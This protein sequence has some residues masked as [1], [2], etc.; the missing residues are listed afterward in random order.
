MQLDPRFHVRYDRSLR[1][2]RNESLNARKK[3]RHG[4]RDHIWWSLVSKYRCALMMMMMYPHVR[5]HAHLLNSVGKV[6]GGR[7]E[8]GGGTV[9]GT[10]R[11]LLPGE[12]ARF[13]SPL[14]VADS[15]CA[16]TKLPLEILPYRRFNHTTTLR[17]TLPTYPIGATLRSQSSLWQINSDITL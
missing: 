15:K 6:S 16:T 4:V 8:R 3:E 12:V 17:H 11:K 2:S 14:G 9:R 7:R 10:Q 1:P 13:W 5:A